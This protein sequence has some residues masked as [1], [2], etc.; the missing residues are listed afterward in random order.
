[1]KQIAEAVVETGIV[2]TKEHK[3]HKDGNELRELV[4]AVSE[5]LN[6]GGGSWDER[7]LEARLVLSGAQRLLAG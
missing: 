4:V 1:M 3:E 2:A 6:R 7:V 5:I